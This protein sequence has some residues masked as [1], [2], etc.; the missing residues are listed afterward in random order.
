MHSW[1]MRVFVAIVAL[2]NLMLTF[3]VGPSALTIVMIP[4]W[5]FIAYTFLTDAIALAIKES[6]KQSEAWHQ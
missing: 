6:H 4:L 3:N 2:M 1:R 5:I